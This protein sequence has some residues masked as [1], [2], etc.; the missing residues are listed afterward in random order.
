MRKLSLLVLAAFF[1]L[2]PGLACGP[3]EAEFQYGATEMRAAIEGDW[4][5]SITPTG[6]AAM[7]Y[8]VNLKQASGNNPAAARS[9][10][11][12][13][14]RQAHACGARTLV[15]SAA[16][17]IDYSEMPLDVTIKEGSATPAGMSANYRVWSLT[18]TTGDLTLPLNGYYVSAQIKPDGTVSSASLAP[19]GTAGMSGSVTMR[20]L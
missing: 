4:A 13:L 8:V 11:R 9:T 12:G 3:A 7:E 17:C 16:A 15:A 20:R 10:R 18:F 2:N 19:G 1:F 6:G 14:V 5:V